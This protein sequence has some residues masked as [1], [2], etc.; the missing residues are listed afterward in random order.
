MKPILFLPPVAALLAVSIWI[1]QG[2]RTITTLEEQSAVLRQR[3][4][5]RTAGA[6]LG[7]DPK[8]PDAPTKS[9]K[10]VKPIDWKEF[11]AQLLEM[12][13]GGG[14]GDMRS[15]IRI[16]QRIQAMTR[17]EIVTALDE[18]QAGDF[19]ADAKEMLEQM[20]IGPLCQKD[21]EFAL[22]RYLDRLDENSGGISWQLSNAMREWAAKDS[23]A[24][25][26]WFD[27]QIADGKFDSKSLDGKSQP[28]MQFEGNLIGALISTDPKA[29]ANRLQGLP[30]DQRQE[31]LRS[32]TGN[33][34]KDEDQ[35]AF[36]TFV[37]DELDGSEQVDTLADLA[38]RGSWNEG[39]TKTDDYLE[40]IEATPAERAA[41]V[42][43]VAQ[44]KVRYFTQQKK[45]SRE[46]I[47]TLRDWATKQAPQ[48]TD[49]MTGEAIARATQGQNKLDFSEAAAMA[50]EY[51]DSSGNDDVLE[52]FLS[53][54]N[55]IEQNKDEARVLAQKISDTA[56]RAA[57]LKKL[58]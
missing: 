15:M 44:N 13:N 12:R 38:A 55:N 16:Q 32:W 56:R 36:A 57:V 6:D 46:N 4:A 17:D 18:I 25:T 39:F 27:K 31:V 51:H 3:L 58:N 41:T 35:L 10:E 42:E 45:I 53:Q 2:R 19:S 34:V 47:D 7:A 33:A 23:T 21:P 1:T 28:R 37:R 30:E 48:T 9:A 11:A 52:A 22:N 26:A 49:K 14:M 54:N 5:L 24:A 20:L 40:R 50:V 29:A 43:K 8:R